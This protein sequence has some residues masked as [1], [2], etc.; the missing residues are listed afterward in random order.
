MF[1]KNTKFC[2]ELKNVRK[3]HEILRF[4][5]FQELR[6]RHNIRVFR[7]GGGSQYFMRSLYT[8]Y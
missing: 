1:A 3:K 8:L 2:G 4:I 6:T 7:I 5:C